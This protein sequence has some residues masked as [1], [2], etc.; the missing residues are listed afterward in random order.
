MNALGIDVSKAKLDCCLLR[1]DNT[2]KTKV[3][4]NSAA[5]FATLLDWCARQGAAIQQSRAAVEGTGGYHQAVVRALYDA[6]MSV[7]VANPAR[8]R[9]FAQS[10]GLLTKNDT[11][12]AFAL[13][14]FIQTTELRPWQPPPPRSSI[15]KPWPRGARLW[16]KTCSG[17]RTAW[18]RPR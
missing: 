17:K 13:A 1:E 4:A 16:P 10:Q 6:G 14:R 7:C 15:C 2:R 5:G 18:K 9:Q 3:V 11:I 8:A 12:D